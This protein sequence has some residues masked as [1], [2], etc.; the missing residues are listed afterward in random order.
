MGTKDG[1]I[2]EASKDGRYSI[3]SVYEVIKAQR[4]ENGLQRS[5]M[6]VLASVWK[7]PAP[8]KAI[9][10]SW[11]L[12]RNRLP[13]CDNLRKR[14]INM[15]EEDLQCCFCQDHEEDTNHMFISCPKTQELWDEIQRWT[16]I[17]TA[18][19][20]AAA[21]HWLNFSEC[22]Q[23]KKGRKLLKAIWMSCCWLLWKRRN[24]IRFEGKTW[25]VNN[26]ILEIKVRVWSWNKI[27]GVVDFDLD[28]AQ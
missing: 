5:D 13:T 26:L 18:Q 9:V 17:S 8:Q 12:L 24:E 16:G 11:R 14:K 3:K 21:A 6:K 23:N 15:S 27:F 19:P 4:S 2:W 10:T 25:E 7:T 1:W 22:G 20:F 28:F